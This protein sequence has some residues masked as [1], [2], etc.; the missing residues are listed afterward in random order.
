MACVILTEDL[1]AN[2]VFISIAMQQGAVT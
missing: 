1:Y 2:N